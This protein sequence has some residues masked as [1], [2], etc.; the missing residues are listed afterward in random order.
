MNGNGDQDEAFTVS[1]SSFTNQLNQIELINRRRSNT[2]FSFNSISSTSDSLF[3]ETF[4]LRFDNEGEESKR[5]NRIER[6]EDHTSNL[7]YVGRNKSDDRS[8]NSTSNDYTPPSSLESNSDTYNTI[9]VASYASVK[10]KSREIETKGK[11][12]SLVGN[13]LEIERHEEELLTM[14]RTLS[15]DNSRV[16][17]EERVLG[18]SDR[19][20]AGPS[21]SSTI[22]PA[23]FVCTEPISSDY[24]TNYSSLPTSPLASPV[25]PTLPN[26]EEESTRASSNSPKLNRIKRSFSFS[27]PPL[28]FNK[29]S[30]SFSNLSFQ[31]NSNQK[32]AIS[33]STTSPTISTTG[34]P[35]R[36]TSLTSL[37][38]LVL[39]NPPDSPAEST[40]SSRRSWRVR[41]KEK[42]S[43]VLPS[44]PKIV[45]RFALS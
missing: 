11:G 43:K 7:N 28:L 18:D 20:K 3:D 30:R 24:S 23:S 41:S 13:S 34:T 35:G 33:S 38:V 40:T 14:E 22:F 4:N 15:R 10:G 44:L 17:E 42:L 31:L 21:S 37:L 9:Q 19:H 8:L 5:C 1:S 39:N 25:I 36:N 2:L 29:N 6:I 27:R 26:P 12:K 45:R 32:S 16:E